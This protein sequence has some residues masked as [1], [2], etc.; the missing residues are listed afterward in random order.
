MLK[1]L[2]IEAVQCVNTAGTPG[3]GSECGPGIAARCGR[4]AV[5][6][7]AK[8]NTDTEQRM[9]EMGHSTAAAAAGRRHGWIGAAGC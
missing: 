2:F 7:D 6:G 4:G 8:R 1:V 9:G 3:D 5:T